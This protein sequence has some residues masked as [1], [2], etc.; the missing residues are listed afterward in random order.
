MTV[1]PIGFEGYE[2]RLEINFSE[3]SVFT[4]PKGS[5]LRVLTRS[6]IDSILEPAACTIV[7]QL[8]NSE[9]DSYVLSESSLFV[10]PYKIVIKTC[11]TTKLLLSIPQILKLA[12]SI[13]LRVNSVRYSRGTFIFQNTQP[14][15]HRS[16]S[17]EVGF[18]NNYFKTGEAFILGAPN[19]PNRYW[20]VYVAHPGPQKSTENE[21][22]VEMCMTGLDRAKASVFHKTP[23][24]DGEMTKLSGISNIIPSHTI[25]DF[26]FEPCGYSMNGI[27]N[28]AYSTV[29]VTPEEGFSYASYEVMGFNPTTIGFEQMV[30]RVL[31]CFKPAEFS[32]AITSNGSGDEWW[33]SVVG[34][35]ECNIGVKQE[36]PGGSCIVYLCFSVG[37]KKRRSVSP[38]SVL[39]CRER[40]AE[41]IVEATEAGDKLFY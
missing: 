32:I 28:A 9:F 18:L 36:L 4:D 8:S 13:S 6:Q 3:S 12:E 40:F 25:C 35:Y 19:S 2:K 5:G 41:D 21:I 38:N 33:R 29:H 30:K 26:E 23:E 10:F 7:A 22:T 20:H 27:D 39:K 34:G 31:E 24:N 16:F 15:P 17:E 14:A 37:E 1:S 11:G